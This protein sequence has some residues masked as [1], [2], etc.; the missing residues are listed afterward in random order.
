LTDR[1]RWQLDDIRG[2]KTINS[3]VSTAN[4]MRSSFKNNARCLV[5]TMYNVFPGMS[6]LVG[7]SE[8]E[9]RDQVKQKVSE[10][11]QDHSFLYDQVSDAM[12]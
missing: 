6:E 11:L 4:T 12:N 2:E 1:Q 3:V 5:R 10:L 7:L 8:T 9:T